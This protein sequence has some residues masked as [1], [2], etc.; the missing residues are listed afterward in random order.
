MLGQFIGSNLLKGRTPQGTPGGPPLGPPGGHLQSLPGGPPQGPPRGSPQGPTGGPPQ[1]SPG[2]HSQGLPV[3]PLFY[4]TFCTEMEL[5]EGLVQHNFEADPDFCP[6]CGAI[7]NF[8]NA[9]EYVTC[10][11]CKHI[12]D[13]SD[14]MKQE[15]TYSVSFTP[16]GAYNISKKEEDKVEL[17]QMDNSRECSKCGNKGM[18]YTTMQLR[19][20][21]EGQTI[22]YLC[23]KCKHREV[24]NS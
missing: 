15:K 22:F 12:V 2:G 14:L 21:D 3:F 17:G 16:Y 19:S 10:V 20:A 5:G 18:S 11:V 13:L 1:S 23:P 6:S 4:N 24:E 8:H 9:G 7:L